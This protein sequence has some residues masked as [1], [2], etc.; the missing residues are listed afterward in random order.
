MEGC[1]LFD[2]VAESFKP[3]LAPYRIDD[4]AW[5]TLNEDV[6]KENE[7]SNTI[8]S[9]LQTANLDVGVDVVRLRG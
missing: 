5:Q 9:T 8:S 3:E 1:A 2:G 4:G 7:E 6:V